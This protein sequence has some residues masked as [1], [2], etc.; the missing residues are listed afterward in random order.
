M[1]KLYN[2]FF[3]MPKHGKVHD[4]V[5]LIR[6]VVTMV[7]IVICL[8]SMSITAYAYFSYDITSGSNIIKSA[9]FNAQISIT[10]ENSNLVNPSSIDGKKTVFTFTTPG[11]YSVKLTKGNSTAKTGFCI[12]YIGEEKYLT[13]Q[14]GTD[15]TANNAEREFVE[16]I[17]KI[18]TPNTDV[19][20]ES[21]WGTSSNYDFCST[22]EN[23][24]Y[25]VNSDPKKE[26]VIGKSSEE[27]SETDD[28][29]ET[30]QYKKLPAETNTKE[31]STTTPNTQSSLT[32]KNNTQS[33]AV[34]SITTNPTELTTSP[35]AKTS[36]EQTATV[37]KEA[38]EIT[39]SKETLS[40]TEVTDA[41]S[42]EMN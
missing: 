16:F 38:T 6:T 39:S 30:S 5:M 7:V 3:S 18:N 24:C 28:S 12:V 1:K 37:S 14:I 20:I 35:E 15:I 31:P 27:I 8:A 17:L 4:K 11:A 22:S 9:N 2:E 26:I 40:K 34:T 42:T 36:T 25:I 32:T 33:T 19:A 21:N 29:K 23:V 41:I 10:D 13:Q